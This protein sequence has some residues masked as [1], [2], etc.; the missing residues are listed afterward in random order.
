VN[1]HPEQAVISHC[2]VGWRDQKLDQSIWQH[3]SWA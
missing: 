2:F 3:C 1:N